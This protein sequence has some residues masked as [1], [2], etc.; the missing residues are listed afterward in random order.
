MVRQWFAENNSDIIEKACASAGVVA[1]RIFTPA[2]MFSSPTFAA[3]ESLVEVA[4][5]E[6]GPV[7]VTGVVPRLTNFP[8]SVRSTGPRLGI[9]GKSVLTEWLGLA[10]SEYEALVSSGVVG[11]VDVDVEVP[12]H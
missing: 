5:Q 9:H 12:G 7:R 6:L 1:A 4:D 2:E 3:R 8:G 10:D 11:A